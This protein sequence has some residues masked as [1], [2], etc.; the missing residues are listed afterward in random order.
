MTICAFRGCLPE[1][2]VTVED[3][4]V[5][6]GHHFVAAYFDGQL[7][8]DGATQIL[9]HGPVGNVAVQRDREGKSR[10]PGDNQVMLPKV[11]E[12]D[13][14]LLVL[15][16]AARIVGDDHRLPHP[17][18]TPGLAERPIRIKLAPKL[19]RSNCVLKLCETFK[20]VVRTCSIL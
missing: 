6:D 17:F 9:N 7:L 16:D 20:R 19:A 1:I 13:K 12:P 4:R 8:H 2:I 5:V 18:D 3:I 14:Q 10:G 15:F 11:G